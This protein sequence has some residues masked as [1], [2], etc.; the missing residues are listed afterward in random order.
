M[1]RP[2]LFAKRTVLVSERRDIGAKLSF[3][4]LARY[5]VPRER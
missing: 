1:A 2:E 4:R 5:G 3:G